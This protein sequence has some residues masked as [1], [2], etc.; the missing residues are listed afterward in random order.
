MLTCRRPVVLV[1]LAHDD[2]VVT[3]PERT[4]E[5]RDWVK[6]H[7]RVGAFSLTSARPIVVPHR[8][9]CTHNRHVSCSNSDVVRQCRSFSE[10]LTRFHR[11]TTPVVK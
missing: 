2:L 6:K 3:A 9:L 5:Q 10:N 4:V 1:C 8:K 7:V 11:L